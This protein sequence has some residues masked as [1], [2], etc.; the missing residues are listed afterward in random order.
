MPSACNILS[1]R[2]ESAF[3]T[4]HG[5][6][7]EARAK[8]RHLHPTGPARHPHRGVSNVKWRRFASSHYPMGSP[9][10]GGNTQRCKGH[11]PACCRPSRQGFPP[12]TVGWRRST[13]GCVPST[14]RWRSR[15]RA[16]GA[17]EGGKRVRPGRQERH[18]GAGAG[19]ASD[20]S[21]N[22]IRIN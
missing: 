5:P 18:A 1:R 19:R 6:W 3:T 12:P 10:S 11:R 4:C 8:A 13:Q 2:A 16:K 14:I 7:G 15:P 20:G 21:V 9:P 17:Q 22:R